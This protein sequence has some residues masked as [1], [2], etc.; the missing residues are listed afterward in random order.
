MILV[1]KPLPFPGA[2][3]VFKSLSDP[4]RLRIV[5]LLLERELCVCE[6]M[7]VL[8]MAQSRVSHQLRLLRDAGLVV[9]TREGRWIV[10]RIPP[11]IR[12]VLGS[13]FGVFGMAAGEENSSDRN[14]AA[15]CLRLELRKSRGLPDR[16][17]P[18]VGSRKNSRGKSGRKEREPAMDDKPPSSSARLKPR[19]GSL[20][21]RK[22]K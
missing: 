9:D 10:Y 16:T 5:R 2:L 20:Q 19:A 21:S 15:A 11:R 6:L 17:G 13:L 14:R 4:T 8:Q 1:T 3:R 7:F 22:S 18:D 12:P